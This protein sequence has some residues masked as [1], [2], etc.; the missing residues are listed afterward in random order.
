MTRTIVTRLILEVESKFSEIGYVRIPAEKLSNNSDQ[1]ENMVLADGDIDALNLRRQIRIAVFRR[2][3]GAY[4]VFGRI[5]MVSD[6]VAGIFN[7]LPEAARL[8]AN[9]GPEIPGTIV[10]TSL[11]DLIGVDS[12]M[13]PQI[14]EVGEVAQVVC[15]LFR[16]VTERGSA[17]FAEWST[18]DS[19]LAAA[20]H[21]QRVSFARWN[22]DPV[23][24]RAAIV[25][26]V[27]NGEYRSVSR[28]MDWYLRRPIGM[29]DSD[30][31]ERARALEEYLQDKFVGY[32]KYRADSGMPYPHPGSAD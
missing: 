11:T 21:R 27:C 28:S 15:G 6:A 29:N 17:W 4:Q 9:L 19:L 1:A 2:S 7:S 23:A 31:R 22:I 16:I 32:R 14:F 20:C 24:F 30:S 12:Q 18:F 10:E 26:G 8:H 3:S 5:A 13:A 25:L